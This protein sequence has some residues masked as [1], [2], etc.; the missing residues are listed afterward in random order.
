[1]FIQKAYKLLLAL[2][3]PVISAESIGS[4]CRPPQLASRSLCCIWGGVA[5]FTTSP[6]PEKNRR[7]GLSA[8]I[9][10]GEPHRVQIQFGITWAIEM[11]NF[12]QVESS[13]S[14]FR[15]VLLDQTIVRCTSQRKHSEARQTIHPMQLKEMRPIIFL[16]NQ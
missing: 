4:F 11:L 12:Y 2:R 13:I 7:C 15:Q 6:R 8:A 14:L 10:A 9:A 16:V 3:F 5:L 1:M